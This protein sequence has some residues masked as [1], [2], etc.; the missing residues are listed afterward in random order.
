MFLKVWNTG[1]A[2]YCR[3]TADQLVLSLPPNLALKLRRE[4]LQ[5]EKLRAVQQWRH[6]DP[7]MHLK[8]VDVV[9]PNLQVRGAWQKL[10][11][12][13]HSRIASRMGHSSF[14]YNSAFLSYIHDVCLF[15]R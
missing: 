1:S 14:V 5:V 10:K 15:T 3:H 13:A 2:E 11:V 4:V 9:D 8:H 6:P 7:L 12:T